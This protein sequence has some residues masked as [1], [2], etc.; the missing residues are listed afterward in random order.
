MTGLSAK[1]VA[2]AHLKDLEYQSEFHCRSLTYWYDEK[3]GNAF[4]LFEAPDL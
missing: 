3:S 1:V 2:E 4:C